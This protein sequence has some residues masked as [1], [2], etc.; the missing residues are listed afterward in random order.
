[1]PVYGSSP[2]NWAYGFSTLLDKMALHAIEA[3]TH[4]KVVPVS[5]PRAFCKRGLSLRSIAWT[6]RGRAADVL[7]S[8]PR[9]RFALL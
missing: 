1:M 3:N 7:I 2:H 8:V 5:V 9:R 6:V 4:R